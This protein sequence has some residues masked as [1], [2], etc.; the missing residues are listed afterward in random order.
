MNV[1][2]YRRPERALIEAAYAGAMAGEL[3]A[4]GSYIAANCDE[5]F[6]EG[7]QAWFDATVRQDA[8]SGV[9]S[10]AELRRRDPLLAEVMMAVWGD[11]RWRYPRTAPAAFKGAVRARRRRLRDTLLGCFMA[12]GSGRKRRIRAE[13]S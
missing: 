10:R 5:Y 9:T 13:I 2:L 6:A 4:P 1:G 3:Y 7:T 11:G 8:T 12:P